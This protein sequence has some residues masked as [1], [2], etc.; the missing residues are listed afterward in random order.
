MAHFVD[1]L[2]FFVDFIGIDLI[3]SLMPLC[4]VKRRHGAE[5]FASK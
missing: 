4:E 5:V 3:L 2:R 1:V